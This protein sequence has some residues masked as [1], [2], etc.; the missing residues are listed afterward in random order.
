MTLECFDRIR[1]INLVERRDRRR[2]ME[3]ELAGI[4]LADDPRV[5]FI[6]ALRPNDAGNFTSVGARGGVYLG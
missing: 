5:A 6:S 1:V 2:D 4:G 3:R